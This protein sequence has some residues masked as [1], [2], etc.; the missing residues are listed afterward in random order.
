MSWS[1]LNIHTT[2]RFAFRIFLSLPPISRFTA[3]EERNYCQTTLPFPVSRDFATPYLLHLIFHDQ[4]DGS[5][6][7][8]FSISG[9]RNDLTRCFCAW[10][11][12]KQQYLKPVLHLNESRRSWG[13][14]FGLRDFSDRLSVSQMLCF[15]PAFPSVEG[16]AY[17]Y[18]LALNFWVKWKR[19]NGV[20]LKQPF[21][22]VRP[23]TRML[24]AFDEKKPG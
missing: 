18:L 23:S 6:R 19:R 21:K 1:V 24:R 8:P 16:F 9:M 20:V 12:E 4:V 17:S 15:R 3:H 14:A 13:G 7:F 2:E 10:W 22:T 5:L 11:R